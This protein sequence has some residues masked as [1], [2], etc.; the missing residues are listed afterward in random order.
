[1]RF[2]KYR[3]KK[4]RPVIRRRTVRVKGAIEILL[5]RQDGWAEKFHERQIFDAWESIVGKPAA[6]QSVPVSLSGGILRVKVGHPV[7]KTELSAMKTDILTKLEKKIK[8]LNAGM[9]KPSKRRKITD[10]WFDLVTEIPISNVKSTENTDKSDSDVSERVAKPVPPEMQEQA[11][12]A[13]L[14]VNDSEL[15]TALKTLFLTQSSYTETA[16]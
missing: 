6:S 3:K 10:I 11:E 5:R 1:M 15:R 14:A 16:E 4:R 8:N 9:R 2:K 13:V 12:A 7:Y